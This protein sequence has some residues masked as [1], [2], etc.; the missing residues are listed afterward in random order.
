MAGRGCCG[1][2]WVCYR[3]V[4]YLVHEFVA[5]FS[6]A[7][8]AVVIA[9]C[10]HFVVGWLPVAQSAVS[11]TRATDDRALWGAGSSPALPSPSRLGL[12]RL[13]LFLAKR[14]Q[15][16]H[17]SSHFHLLPANHW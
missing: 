12:I 15:A 3:T 14:C 13:S 10:V 8:L 2:G 5:V 4:R 6:R 16:H 7:S 9:R 1:L 17:P 11:V